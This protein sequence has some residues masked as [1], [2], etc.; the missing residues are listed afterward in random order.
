MPVRAMN[1]V[2]GFDQ[3]WS[4]WLTQKVGA[5]TDFQSVAY[6]EHALRS[7]DVERFEVHGVKQQD[8]I[9]GQYAH[10]IEE[11]LKNIVAEY[12]NRPGDLTQAYQEILGIYLRE[13]QYY[14]S[15]GKNGVT[16]LQHLISEMVHFGL[17]GPVITQLSN[18][19]AGEKAIHPESIQADLPE[20]EKRQRAMSR[21]LEPIG[22]QG[23]K[24]TLLYDMGALDHLMLAVAAV[25]EVGKSYGAN[26]LVA[27]VSSNRENK[28]AGD[29]L[30][31]VDYTLRMLP[32][33]KGKLHGMDYFTNGDQ[34][35]TDAIQAIHGA[36]MA[37]ETLPAVV[38]DNPEGAL[39][40]ELLN[41]LM[42]DPQLYAK[43]VFMLGDYGDS[44]GLGEIRK[45]MIK[46]LVR[47]DSFSALTEPGP[48]VQL[49][50][51][52]GADL[53]GI[54]TIAE[55]ALTAPLFTVGHG[56]HHHRTTRVSDIFTSFRELSN[57]LFEITAPGIDEPTKN[58]RRT[59]RNVVLP[60]TRSALYRVEEQKE[61]MDTPQP[62]SED[63][64]Q[65]S[66]ARGV[67]RFGKHIV[68]GMSTLLFNKASR[69]IGENGDAAEKQKAVDALLL[70]L[71]INTVFV[72]PDGFMPRR[73]QKKLQA[74]LGDLVVRTYNLLMTDE[75]VKPQSEKVLTTIL[76]YMY[77]HW[78]PKEIQGVLKRYELDTI[79]NSN[80][81]AFLNGRLKTF[82][83]SLMLPDAEQHLEFNE[84]KHTTLLPSI[85]RFVGTTIAERMP[86]WFGRAGG[87]EFDAAIFTGTDRLPEQ[88]R[89]QFDQEMG[90]VGKSVPEITGPA[91]FGHSV[92]TREWSAQFTQERATTMTHALDLMN[93][94]AVLA[95]F[96]D[97]NL[98]YKKEN[99]GTSEEVLFGK[100]LS[101]H[102][103]GPFVDPIRRV[104]EEYRQRA[105]P[106]A[107]DPRMGQLE[108]QRGIAV[109]VE[110][111]V[112]ENIAVQAA[113]VQEHAVTIAGAKK[114]AFNAMGAILAEQ[115]LTA[116]YPKLHALIEDELKV[117][118]S[119]RRESG[120]LLALAEAQPTSSGA[121][122][123]LAQ[124]AAE[125]S[126]T[127]V[128]E[129]QQLATQLAIPYAQVVQAQELLT[130]TQ[131]SLA[132]LGMEHTRVLSF[133][134]TVVG[135]IADTREAQLSM[136]HFAEQ[137]TAQEA[138]MIE[139]LLR[140]LSDLGL[141]R[142]VEVYRE[143]QVNTAQV[144]QED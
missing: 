68:G 139:N 39:G 79:M 37:C 35:V 4:E 106:E 137:L 61:Q 115:G 36:T 140:Q 69:L 11:S 27:W 6:F 85:A 72:S 15:Q 18:L 91:V 29:E 12:G 133:I 144:T 96:I 113:R 81:A 128:T 122:L 121:I 108:K 63:R 130:R 70:Q 1:V 94:L 120:N 111:T 60:M 100:E 135:A 48:S 107:L 125:Q 118:Q 138:H 132:P 74:G 19:Q 51:S 50:H 141:T 98:K 101:G 123:A 88:L 52:D 67:E 99:K 105:V 31:F 114:E 136:I 90:L 56:D 127:Q 82:V 66:A 54:L 10:F 32:A 41:M 45:Q 38:V 75:S 3:S 40:Q 59:I 5:P 49:L 87:A 8:K 97:S 78:E 57:S 17:H 93:Q 30:A 89:A 83:L 131:A 76:Q 47:D 117:M 129:L 77:H 80:A 34:V 64:L 143:Q 14:Y 44:A 62:S 25:G 102:L 22:E 9:E 53:R 84:E 7:R 42:L 23:T 103:V 71:M 21:A 2:S 104:F 33:T 28:P 92:Q 112:L 73:E 16:A 20:T 126:Q 43:V 95:T 110:N 26:A 13:I 55:R 142:L 65:V 46:Q 86:I 124:A 58:T 119:Q 109:Q 116:I 134:T 24:D